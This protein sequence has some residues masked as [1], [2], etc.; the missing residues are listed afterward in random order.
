MSSSS[1]DV[2]GQLAMSSDDVYPRP[3]HPSIVPTHM[4]IKQRQKNYIRNRTQYKNTITMSEG[5]LYVFG[6]TDPNLQARWLHGRPYRA[7]ANSGERFGSIDPNPHT[8]RWVQ[9]HVKEHLHCG[10]A[11]GSTNPNLDPRAWV[12]VHFTP[13]WVWVDRPKPYGPVVLGR[14]GPSLHALG[15]LGRST[16]TLWTGG[17]WSSRPIPACA[18]GLGRSTQTL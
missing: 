11:F 9:A 1:S 5:V 12:E 16:Q 13:W 10:E 18:G 6:S 15:G 14:P 8:A 4:N 2:D 7:H 3:L 17:A